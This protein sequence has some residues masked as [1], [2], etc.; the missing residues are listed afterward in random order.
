MPDNDT[1]EQI[2]NLLV[3]IE[4]REAE[5]K[6]YKQRIHNLIQKERENNE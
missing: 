5:I 1:V 6:I 2:Y 3:G 4:V